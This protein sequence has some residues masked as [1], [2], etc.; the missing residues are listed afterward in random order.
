MPRFDTPEP[1][2][3]RVYANSGSIRLIA[4]ERADTVVE[5]RPRNESRTADVRSAEDARI[6][7]THG[8]LTVS[9]AKFGLLGARM[10]AVDIT[11]ELPASSRVIVAVASADVQADGQF[12]DFRF[13]SASGNLVV[14]SIAGAAKIATASGDTTV[15]QLDGDLKF[16]AASGSLSLN[17][18]R[19]NVKSQTASGS[20]T[21]SNAVSGS[22]FAHTSSGQV[23]IGIPDGT[24]ADLNIA[25]GSGTITNDIPSADGPEDGDDTLRVQVRTASGDVDVHRAV[26][27]AA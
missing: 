1:V 15:E 5:I 27:A 26:T 13:D 12:C 3:A 7:Y 21:V 24:A 14:E 16:Q 25:S 17:R 22:V 23:E 9:P 19:G 10:G 18:L 4:T 2:M 11:I 8:T 20:V 6:D